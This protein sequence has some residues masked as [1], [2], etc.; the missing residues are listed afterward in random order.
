[1]K[2]GN[3]VDPD[4]VRT[5]YHFLHPKI[6]SMAMDNVMV[7]EMLLWPVV[8]GGVGQREIRTPPDSHSH[9]A[10]TCPAKIEAYFA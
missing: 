3:L 9:T 2:F 4:S 7:G 10:T 6:G 8:H 5:I 1:M